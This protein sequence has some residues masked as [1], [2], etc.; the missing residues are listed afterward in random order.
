MPKEEGNFLKFIIML[1][2]LA[3]SVIRILIN[4]LNQYKFGYTGIKYE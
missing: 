1:A 2:I 3:G 4:H